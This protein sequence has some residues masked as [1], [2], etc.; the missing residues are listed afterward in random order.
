MNAISKKHPPKQLGRQHRVVVVVVVESVFSASNSLRGYNTCFPSK[1]EN[2]EMLSIGACEVS[3]TS[4]P[5]KRL[6]A[7]ATS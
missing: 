7:S 6:Y 4:T 1:Y 5:V 2:D 3:L